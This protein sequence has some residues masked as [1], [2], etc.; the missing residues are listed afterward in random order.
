MP[1]GAGRKRRGLAGEVLED[2][3]DGVVLLDREVLPQCVRERELLLAQL[4]RLAIFL[5]LRPRHPD[6]VHRHAREL[7]RAEAEAGDVILMMVRRHDH[8]DPAARHLDD[9]RDDVLH[10]VDVAARVHA[11]VDQHVLPRARADGGERDQEAV[12]EADAVHADADRPR[13]AL[14]LRSRHRFLLA[15]RH[16]TT[17]C[18]TRGSRPLAPACRACKSAARGTRRSAGSSRPAAGA[19]RRPSRSSGS[20]TSRCRRR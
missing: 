11:A 7:F 19:G 15:E 4:L 5:V 14:R 18:A 9:V 12:A 13:A 2:V 10:R 8:C 6:F 1:S 3:I 20:R 16:L 17:P